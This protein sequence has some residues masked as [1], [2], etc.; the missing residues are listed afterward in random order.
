MVTQKKSRNFARRSRCRR[1]RTKI[2][3]NANCPRLCVFKSNKY[4]YA[5]LIDDEQGQVLAASFQKSGI[6]QATQVG[7]EIAQKALKKNI[8]KIVFD[9]SGYKYHGQVKALAEGARKQGLQ[10]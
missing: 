10:F 4:L 5:Q 1:L 8:K 7:E 3:G 6:K 2:K 9:R